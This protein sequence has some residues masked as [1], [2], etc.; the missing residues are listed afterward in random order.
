MTA[1]FSTEPWKHFRF[2]GKGQI[3]IGNYSAF[4]AREREAGRLKQILRFRPATSAT[5][6]PSAGPRAI[7]QGGESLRWKRR[8]AQRS[9]KAEIERRRHRPAF[10]SG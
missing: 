6:T 4:E 3:D 5:A 8:C 1:I 10:R 2:E 9:Q 7:I